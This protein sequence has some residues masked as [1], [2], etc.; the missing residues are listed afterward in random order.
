MR[1]TRQRWSPTDI[2]VPLPEIRLPFLA[3][4]EASRFRRSLFLFLLPPY[5]TPLCASAHRDLLSTSLPCAG[6]P[7]KSD[8]LNQALR[9]ASSTGVFK[10]HDR[11]TH[12]FNRDG[13]LRV[14]PDG[15]VVVSQ[16]QRARDVLLSAFHSMSDTIL[17]PSVRRLSDG[18]AAARRI[19][20]LS[21]CAVLLVYGAFEL[22]GSQPTAAS[23]PVQTIEECTSSSPSSPAVR[24]NSDSTPS[25]S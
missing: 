16:L 1:T 25:S 11:A 18:Y 23:S 7:R 10:S 20:G 5:R 3:T 22:T 13:P 17:R 6:L 24:P 21:A 4:F 12:A 2:A 14:H 9:A 8:R 15:T 19:I